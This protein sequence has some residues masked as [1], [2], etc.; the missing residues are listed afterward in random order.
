[1]HKS[2]EK[3]AETF[4]KLT[5]RNISFTFKHLV[6]SIQMY[7]MLVEKK[8]NLYKTQVLNYIVHLIIYQ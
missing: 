8:I 5:G 7:K 4:F 2:A 1:M 6:D 3:Y